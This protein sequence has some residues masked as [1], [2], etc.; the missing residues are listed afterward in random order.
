MEGQ[1]WKMWYLNY[2]GAQFSWGGR[3][4]KR[5]VDSVSILISLPFF[6]INEFFEI[7]RLVNVSSLLG[8]LFFYVSFSWNASLLVYFLMVREG[9]NS[10]VV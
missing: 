5:G 6:A 1:Y 2:W 7:E 4:G 9:E 10:F 8:K 3:R